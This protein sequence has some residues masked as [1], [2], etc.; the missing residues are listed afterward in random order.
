MFPTLH[1][2]ID[3]T[4]PQSIAIVGGGL[5]GSALA[6]MLA[7]R[8]HH[9]DV[10]E[11]RS[12]PCAESRPTGRSTHLVI[13]MRGWRV[14]DAIGA[15][16]LV[17]PVTQALKGRRI[18]TLDKGEIFQPYGDDD[19]SIQAIHRSALNRIL[20]RLCA[21][22]PGVTMHYGRR[23]AQVDAECGR[24]W[25]DE[26]D[27]EDFNE[28]VAD[29]IFAADGA[30]STVR[31]RLIQ[32]ERFNYSQ[33]Y[34][35][36]GYKELT[37]P[38]P[39]GCTL[40]SDAMHAW[41]RGEVSLFAFPNPDGS[42]TATLLAPFDGPDGFAS[43]RSG[44]DVRRIFAARFPDVDPEPLIQEVLQNPCSSLVSVRCAPWVIGGRL[45]LIGDAA[46]AM[47]PFLGQ[48]MNAGFEDCAVLCELLDRHNED[49]AAVLPLYDALRRPNCDAVTTMSSR[50]FDELT[51][52]VADPRFHIRKRLEQRIHDLAP[53]RFVPPY[54]HIAF[55]HTPYAEVLENIGELDH[56]VSQLMRD[57]DVERMWDTPQAERRIRA[58]LQPERSPS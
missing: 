24:I 35:P 57:P 42:F 55:T 45:A 20:A 56:L 58:L 14:L 49:F 37:I 47:V 36:F 17:E 30:F 6:R 54:E 26:V 44:D 39:L 27:G 12:D 10:F 18:H 5:V 33:S 22:T 31:Q 48:G 34:E 3:V 53:E 41:P 46:H 9:V 13:S 23:V 25:L 4:T 16:S 50:A 2:S 11:R 52:Q 1:S 7:R 51:R 28:V 19:Q 43:M 15:R 40:A 21:D 32:S 8:G 38:E 29:W